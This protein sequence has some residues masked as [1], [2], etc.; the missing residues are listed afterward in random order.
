[1]VSR[2][3]DE[4]K[5][6]QIDERYAA[7]K[8]HGV[9]FFPDIVYKDMLVAFGVFLLLISLATFLGVKAEPPADPS[10]ASYI[11]RP[12]WYFLFL[13]QMLKYFPGRLEW[14]GTTIVPAAAVLLLLVLPFIDRSPYRHWRKRKIAIGIMSVAVLGIVGLTLMAVA[15]TPPQEE[16]GALTSIGE[17]V[18]A[19]QDLFAV[20]CVEC[21]GD[22]G[23]GGEIS[24]VE[25]LEG[26]KMNPLNVP[27]FMYTRTDDTLYNIIEYGQPDLGMPP[28][29]QAYGGELPRADLL[30]MVAFMRYTWD[31][32]VQLPPDAL[33]A[34]AIPTLAEGETPSYSVHIEPLI[35]RACISC[36][37]PG[38]TNNNFWMRDLNELL[39]TGDHAPN[40][41]AGDLG[42]NL[43]RMLHREEIEAGGPMPPTRELKPE[44]IAIWE[45]WV[46][47]GMPEFPLTPTPGAS[48]TASSVTSGPVPASATPTP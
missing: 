14:I 30:A 31:D 41:V 16:A 47:A 35:R 36:H 23:Q 25:G 1:M 13:F 38:K 32:R 8:Q 19:G 24:G 17:Q 5:R 20:Y 18:V 10:D 4:S 28:F 3:V 46:L 43:I 22:A 45:A 27:E 11:P 21:H 33:A 37:R 15:Q 48:P 2:P 39:T 12:E 34:F 26:F 29:G 9:K 44:W 42:S 7:E 40:L 6:Q